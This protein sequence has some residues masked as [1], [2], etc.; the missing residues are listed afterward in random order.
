MLPALRSAF[1]DDRDIEAEAGLLHSQGLGVIVGRYLLRL[2]PPASM[3]FEQ[4]VRRTLPHHLDHPLWHASFGLP[5]SR[6]RRSRS[7]PGPCGRS[8]RCP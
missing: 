7:L 2:E 8:R 6:S 3:D 5:G 4:L 1:P